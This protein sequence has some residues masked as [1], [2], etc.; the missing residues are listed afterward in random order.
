[1]FFKRAPNDSYVIYLV[2][3]VHRSTT[4]VHAN[5]G[6]IIR[7]RRKYNFELRAGHWENSCEFIHRNKNTKNRFTKSVKSRERSN[8]IPHWKR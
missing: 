4:Y 6:L 5:I 7:V 3:C 8:S 1:M 2:T